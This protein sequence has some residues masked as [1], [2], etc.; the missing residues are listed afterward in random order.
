[1]FAGWRALCASS[2]LWCGVWPIRARRGTRHW[3][4]TGRHR[5]AS[6]SRVW[7][8]KRC[9]SRLVI[10]ALQGGASYGVRSGRRVVDMGARARRDRRTGPCALERICVAGAAGLGRTASA[11]GPGRRVCLTRAR[12]AWAQRD[13]RARTPLALSLHY[14]TE[15]PGGRDDGITAAIYRMDVRNCNGRMRA[16][17]DGVPQQRSRPTQ[18]ARSDAHDPTSVDSAI[19]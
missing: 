15:S 11:G 9:H 8:F 16:R 13:L 10:P 7:R 4:I 3:R 1:M 5:R 2:H 6:S 19:E 17:N 12:G 18:R 14:S